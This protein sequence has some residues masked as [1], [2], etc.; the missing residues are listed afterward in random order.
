MYTQQAKAGASDAGD[1]NT[2]AAVSMFTSPLSPTKR[3]FSTEDEDAEFLKRLAATTDDWQTS[4]PESN[5][6]SSCRLSQGRRADGSD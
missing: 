5:V 6:G 4:L 3:A 1:V 2:P